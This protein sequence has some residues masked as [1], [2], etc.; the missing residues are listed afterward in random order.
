MG[1]ASA[2]DRSMRLETQLLTQFHGDGK[3]PRRVDQ[4]EEANGEIRR[5]KRDPSLSWF[6]GFSGVAFAH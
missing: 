4:Q 1:L 5:T 6:P 2:P 3:W